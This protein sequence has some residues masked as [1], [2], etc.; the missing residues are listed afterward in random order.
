MSMTLP[1]PDTRRAGKMFCWR[2]RRELRRWF[3]VFS[4]EEEG[5]RPILLLSMA[6]DVKERGGSGYVVEKDKKVLEM[7]FGGN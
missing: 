6:E 7:W 3:A 2:E 1:E 4:P 5:E